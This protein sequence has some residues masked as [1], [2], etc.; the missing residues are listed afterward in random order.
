VIIEL[1]GLDLLCIWHV[2]MQAAGIWCQGNHAH[3]YDL[4]QALFM[5]KPPIRV[6]WAEKIDWTE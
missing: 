5:K 2:L 6:A 3:V 4:N 1:N